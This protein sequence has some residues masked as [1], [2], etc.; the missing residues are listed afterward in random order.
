MVTILLLDGIQIIFVDSTLKLMLKFNYS[1]LFSFFWG[2]GGVE[3]QNGGGEGGTEGVNQTDH[4]V[5]FE[6]LI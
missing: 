1:F 6:A 4:W 5:H 2:W 3:G